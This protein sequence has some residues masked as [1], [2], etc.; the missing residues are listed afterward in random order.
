ME[1]EIG[2]FRKLNMGTCPYR[3]DV[4]MDMLRFIH[5]MNNLLD[6]LL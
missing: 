1:L 3:L 4:F 6:H 2:T 5:V